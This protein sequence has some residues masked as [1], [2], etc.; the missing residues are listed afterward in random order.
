MLFPRTLF[1]PLKHERRSCQTT[2]HVA[3][4]L[5]C[6]WR[7]VGK[8]YRMPRLAG[9]WEGFNA[10]LVWV[11]HGVQGEPFQM[12]SCSTL[13]PKVFVVKSAEYVLLPCACLLEGRF[14]QH[15]KPET[16]G[17]FQVRA[18]LCA[19]CLVGNLVKKWL[20]RERCTIPILWGLNTS[21]S[22]KL[23]YAGHALLSVRRGRIQKSKTNV[24]NWGL[25][26]EDNIQYS[27]MSADDY[28]PASSF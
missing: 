21:I 19:S 24:Q 1:V 15:E 8:A 2:I 14:S 25:L 4:P 12:E 26:K 11:Q 13:R 23:S 10:C 7:N 16:L 20:R 18:A 17:L 5:P 27:F 9:H 28:P 3:R 6:F 22:V